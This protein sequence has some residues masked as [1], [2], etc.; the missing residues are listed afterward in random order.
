MDRNPTPLPAPERTHS[1]GLVK[2]EPE[3]DPMLG[4]HFSDYPLPFL[5]T[6]TGRTY[7]AP[8]SGYVL[9]LVVEDIGGAFVEAL[10]LV[11]MSATELRLTRRVHRSSDR[12]RTAFIR[13]EGIDYMLHDGLSQTWLGESGAEAAWFLGGPASRY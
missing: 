2:D 6:W 1:P 11:R 5:G 4:E 7:P 13:Q 12:V 3:V 9:V 8:K 10:D